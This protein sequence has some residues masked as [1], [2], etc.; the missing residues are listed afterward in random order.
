MIRA[1]SNADDIYKPYLTTKETR[2][3][4]LVMV[5]DFRMVSIEDLPLFSF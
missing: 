2:Y 4:E 1:I 5:A 3:N